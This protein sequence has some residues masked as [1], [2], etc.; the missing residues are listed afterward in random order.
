[1]WWAWPSV[2]LLSQLLVGTA[3]TKASDADKDSLAQLQ[4]RKEQ[5]ILDEDF[6]EA[7]RLKLEIE[8]LL[9]RAS[10]KEKSATNSTGGS[11]K[12]AGRY[13]GGVVNLCPDHWPD[14]KAEKVWFVLFY[15]PWCGHC[16]ALEPKFIELAKELKES[17]PGI[18]LGAV[19]CNEVPNQDLCSKQ[20]VHGYPSMLAV[21]MGKSK[22]YHGAREFKPMKAWI[23][24]VHAAKGTKGGSKK[25][26]AGV[27]KS[28]VRDAVVP[29]CDSHWPQEKA[30]H[31]WIIIFYE[32]NGPRTDFRDD[33]NQAAV[34]L[35]SDPPDRNKAL[36]QVQMRRRERL[37]DLEQ[38]YE[39]SVDLPPK[40]PFG[41]ESLAKFGG[42]CCDCSEEMRDFCSQ[43]LGERRNDTLPLKAWMDRGEQ[44]V[45][46]GNGLDARALVEFA[47]QRLGFIEKPEQK[48]E[49]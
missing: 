5:A 15:A 22:P 9:S 36:R 47:L 38:R 4:A 23:L 43:T 35:G 12:C 3:P 26:P 25:C 8:S 31:A 48:D 27:F 24:G 37:M 14:S 41:N 16:R 7:K 11:K 30:K 19:D 18:G 40:G 20:K 10:S 32:E 17:E 46:E 13:K 34:D 28:K 42:V 29:L 6:E 39:L 49:L 1:M 2:F 44:E 33:A 21:V 45:F